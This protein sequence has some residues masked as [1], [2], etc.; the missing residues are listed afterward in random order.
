MNAVHATAFEINA[1]C[2]GFL[3]ALNTVQAYMAAGLYRKALV[4]GGEVLSKLVDWQD[5]NT[6]VLFGDGAGA[7]VVEADPARM[8]YFDQGSDGS[9][10]EALSCPGRPL[11]SPFVA[12][13]QGFAPY[14]FMDGQEV[15]RFAVQKSAGDG[16]AGFTEGRSD[17][18]RRG[19]FPAAPGQQAHFAGGG[20]KES[21]RRSASFP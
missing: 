21:G 5:R 7:A 8:Y 15:F 2:S 11:R 10:G 17:G 13:D 6:C 1:A 19:S 20:Q 9:R 18:R 16:G 12:T 14:I 4:I 3:F